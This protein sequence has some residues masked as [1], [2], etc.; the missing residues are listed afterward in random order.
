ME[1]GFQAT[2]NSKI[3]L[4]PSSAA[5]GGMHAC[6]EVSVQG[7]P[8]GWLKL[9]VDL[10]PTLLAAGGPLL[11]LPTAQVGWQNILDPSQRTPLQY[12]TQV[13]FWIPLLI[14]LGCVG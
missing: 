7:D 1:E 10:V 11:K 12:Q 14:S 6:M 2:F 4:L 3:V 8:S 13:K 5:R 9:S